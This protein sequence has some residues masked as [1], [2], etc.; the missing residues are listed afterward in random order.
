MVCGARRRLPGRGAS[1]SLSL[2]VVSATVF[3]GR[4]Y[5]FREMD[6]RINPRAELFWDDTWLSAISANVHVL[7]RY[8]DRAGS[9]SGH[10]R[11]DQRRPRRAARRLSPLPSRDPKLTHPKPAGSGHAQP[12]LEAS[13]A[14]LEAT[15]TISSSTLNCDSPVM[16]SLSPVFL[17]SILGR[18]ARRP[19]H[20]RRRKVD[21]KRCPCG[22]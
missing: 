4:A 16:K 20:G 7:R 2:R 12:W 3:C 8:R 1:A 22:S 17:A 19:G 14:G 21:V 10:G 11:R 18:G 6:G 15:Q 13:V 5:F 9:G